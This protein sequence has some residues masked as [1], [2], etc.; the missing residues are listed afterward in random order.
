MEQENH[1]VFPYIQN[2]TRFKRNPRCE[3]STLLGNEM[4]LNQTKACSLFS[5]FGEEVCPL[6]PLQ[7]LWK[8]IRR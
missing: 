2:F 6:Q 8:P 5:Q 4:V 7:L 3:E 1:L